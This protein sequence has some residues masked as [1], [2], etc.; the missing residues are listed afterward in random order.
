MSDETDSPRESSNILL[1]FTD[2]HTRYTIGTYGADLCRTP[3]IDRLAAEGLRFDNA[4]TLCAVCAPV[5]TSLLTGQWLHR[6]GVVSNNDTSWATGPRHAKQ[7]RQYEGY[8]DALR[9]R[10]YNLGYFGKWHINDLQE[11][12]PPDYGYEGHDIRGYGNPLDVEDYHE[13]RRSLGLSPRPK[14]CDRWLLAHPLPSRNVEMAACYDEPEEGSIPFWLA[15]RTI[16]RLRRY[17]GDRRERGKPFFIRCD[18]WGPHFSYRLPRRYYEM[19]DPESVPDWPS[20]HYDMAGKP[21]SH[22][23]YAGAWATGDFGL[24]EFQRYRA[25]YYGYVTLI[26][27]AVGRILDAIDALDLTDDLVVCLSSDHGDMLG[28][29]GLVDKGPFMYDDIYRVPLIVRDPSRIAGGATSDAFV[30]NIDLAPTFVRLAGEDV[31][32]CMDAQCL[33][34]P[35][36]AAHPAP[37]SEIVAQFYS[38][39]HFYP[40]RMIRTQRHKYVFNFPDRDELY[41]LDADPHEMANRIDDPALRPALDELRDRLHRW[42]AEEGDPI[43]EAYERT[44]WAKA[45]LS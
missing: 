5:R 21:R 37:R 3:N 39:F 7:P 4:F 9:S 29:H 34:L 10:G 28:A 17:A 35:G 23:I 14:A 27:A 20:R 42:I 22:H 32:A 15:D 6:H 13:Y 1:L 30:Y 38:Q 8:T 43:L 45:G 11:V 44:A 12:G 26:D 33:P 19:Y 24:R 40:Q 41:E 31:P 16:D 18:F 25:L 2:E 36:L